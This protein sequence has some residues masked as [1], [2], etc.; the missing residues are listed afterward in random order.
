MTKKEEELLKNTI[1]SLTLLT[2][3]D[4]TLEIK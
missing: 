1:L 3:K 4:T 2:N